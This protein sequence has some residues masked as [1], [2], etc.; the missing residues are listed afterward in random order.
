M[1]QQTIDEFCARVEARRL[2]AGE[3]GIELPAGQEGIHRSIHRASHRC[4]R[5]G[6]ASAFRTPSAR[7]A[8][9]THRRHPL[10]ERTQ[11][12]SA[13]GYGRSVPP[14][15]RTRTRRLTSIRFRYAYGKVQERRDIV[16][17][18]LVSMNQCQY[19]SFVSSTIT[20]RRSAHSVDTRDQGTH[21]LP[22]R[23]PAHRDARSRSRLSSPSD[24]SWG[25]MVLLRHTLHGTRPDGQSSTGTT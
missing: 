4:R 22:G 17:E 2:E 16:V 19:S 11:Q 24:T 10:N 6:T 9:I 23:R 12:Y 15:V 20:R 25:R 21:P 3:I 7:F 18:Q 8:W 5:N 14:H 13:D 1:Y